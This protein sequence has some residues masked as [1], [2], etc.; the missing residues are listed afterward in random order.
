MPSDKKDRKP[1]LERFIE[2]VVVDDDRGAEGDPYWDDG[3]GG[4]LVARL[5][6]R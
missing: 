2:V 6:R 1:E 4:D 5:R 3:G